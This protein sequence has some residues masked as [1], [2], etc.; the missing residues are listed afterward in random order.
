MRIALSTN[1]AWRRVLAPGDRRLW[2]LGSVALRIEESSSPIWRFE[3]F[4]KRLLAAL[5]LF[6]VTA[7]VLGVTAIFL[8]LDRQP[9]NR[10][11]W[12]DVATIPW[13]YTGFRRKR[14]DSDI[15]AGLAYLKSEQYADAFYRL[16]LGLSRSPANTEGRVM[17]ARLYGGG[18]PG[19]ALKILEEGLPHGA[20]D[21]KLQTVLFALLVQQQAH[22]HGLRLAEGLIAGKHGRLSPEVERGVHFGRLALLQSAGRFTEALVAV[23]GLPVSSGSGWETRRHA[24]EADLLIRLGRTR[25]AD[26]LYATARADGRIGRPDHR[27]E[28]ELAVTLGDAD[29]LQS[30]LRHLMASAPDSPGPY[31]FA[32]QAWHRLNRLTFREAALVDFLRLFARNDGAMQLFAA[33]LVNLDQP[34]VVQQVMRAAVQARLS[35]FAFQVHLTEIALRRGDYAQA[36]RLLRD[37]EDKIDTL[38]ARQRYYPELIKRLARAAFSDDPAQSEAV[39]AHLRGG[40]G[41]A[42]SSVCL[43]AARTLDVAGEPAAALEVV[44]LLERL[45]PQSDPVLELKSR[46]TSRVSELTAAQP[47]T[48]DASQARPVMVMVPGS[49]ADALA[50]ADRLLAAGSL[51]EARDLLR[52]IRARPP[53]W[54]PGHDAAVAVRELQLAFT[55]LDPLAA[56]TQTRGYL[57]KHR[58][59]ADAAILLPL[60]KDLLGK[61]RV[62]DARMLHDE[63][64]TAQPG[65]AALAE[66]LAAVNLPDDLAAL[67]ASRD[68]ALAALDRWLA[69]EQW[70]QAERALNQ[71]A[72]RPPVW[73]AAARTELKLAETRLGFGLD[74]PP[75]ALAAFKEVVIRAGAPRSAA[76]KLAR[77]LH[78]EGRAAQAELLAREVGRLLPGDSAAERLLREVLAPTPGGDKP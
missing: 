66:A 63:L 59:P 72:A 40:A 9:D 67:S 64:L 75:R 76:F 61:Q 41:F 69:N 78:A 50:Q 10:V 11:G 48:P 42:Q 45:Q 44:S 12:S 58:A 19:Q 28:M 46:L 35:P 74:Q 34:E 4:W 14:G 25:E 37:W 62:A 52:A 1:P 6:A 32:Y 5:G 70:P 60:L 13:D 39:L 54:L 3:V 77:D 71:W 24:I 36:T 73:A 53:A 23:R 16:R 27:L 33:A 29:R 17:L 26:Q 47:A 56:R 55:T 18:N 38:P 31:I 7:Y 43:F 51:A 20:D 49:A 22:T 21:L 8:W 30:V 65:N 2:L 15:A 57:Q 68:T